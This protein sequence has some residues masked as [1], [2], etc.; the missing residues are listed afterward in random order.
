MAK[1]RIGRWELDKEDL[2]S[3]SRFV[4]AVAL[5]VW[6]YNLGYNDAMRTV[7]YVHSVCGPGFA[8]AH[9]TTVVIHGA[10]PTVSLPDP[11]TDINICE[12]NICD[13]LVE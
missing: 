9:G 7:E 10:L 8:E 4:L 5:L 1:W 3:F 11:L 13:G 12:H 2:R 6:A